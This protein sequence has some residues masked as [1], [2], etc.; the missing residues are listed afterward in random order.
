MGLGCFV[1]WTD[2]DTSDKG[3]N[4]RVFDKELMKPLTGLI[5]SERDVRE[6]VFATGEKE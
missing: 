1:I 5:T 3:L 4:N 6:K 2:S